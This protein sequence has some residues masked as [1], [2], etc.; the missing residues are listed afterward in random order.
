MSP[1]IRGRRGGVRG[2][3]GRLVLAAVVASAL[4]LGAVPAGALDS[5]LDPSFG[6]DGIVTTG[7]PGGIDETAHAIAIQSDGK[8]VVAGRASSATGGDFGLARYNADGSLDTNADADPGTHFGGDGIVTT[9]VAPANG[10]DDATDVAI[11][12]DGKIVVAGEADMGGATGFDFAVLRYN[13]DGTLDDGG[14]GSDFGGDGVVTTPIG[15]STG[16]DVA[17]GVAIQS[18]GKIVVAGY[19]DMG[20]TTDFDFALARYNADGSLDDAGGGSS[21]DT[22]GIVTTNFTD[23][24]GD[25]E[26]NAVAIQ[27]DGKIVAAGYQHPSAGN[28]DVALARYHVDGSLDTNADADPGTH[29]D[30]DGKVVTSFDPGGDVAQDVAIQ[31]DGKIVAVGDGDD[32]FGIVRY[33]GSDGALDAGFDGDPGNTGGGNGMVATEFA[34]GDS[35]A[36]AQA[37]AIQGDGKL[38]VAGVADV[39]TGAG[40]NQDFALARYNASNGT[41]DD[42][43]AGDGT[44]TTAV[45]GTTSDRALDLRLQSDGKIVAVGEA[46]L[47]GSNDFALARYG[48]D[49]LPPGPTARCAGKAATMVGTA[50]AD[51]LVGTGRRDVIAAL[52]GKDTLRG[53]AGNDILCGGAGRDKLLGG[54]GRDKLLG[55]AGNDILRG[56]PG[57]DRLIGGPGRDRQRQ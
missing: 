15:P 12:S 33:I 17:L 14:G 51:R 26:A 22:D 3:S 49:L 20:G 6:G 16:E 30:S 4:V 24:G 39:D 29:L 52:G 45:A 27:G 19:A 56:G 35:N 8:I 47:A 57:R 28:N 46:T 41:L 38:V 54:P 48:L 1:S 40:L 25:D 10:S 53:R 7:F 18:G 44:V 32:E 42:G 11:Q 21:F 13:A 23:D 43:F 37:I 34:S 2:R 36:N 31:S 50:G 55:Q 5:D 9:P